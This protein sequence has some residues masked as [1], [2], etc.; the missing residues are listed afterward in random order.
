[1]SRTLSRCGSSRSNSQILVSAAKS[2]EQLGRERF[3]EIPCGQVV[4]EGDL[5]RSISGDPAPDQNLVDAIP[6]FGRARGRSRGSRPLSLVRD[7]P[8]RQSA[9]VADRP[10]RMVACLS[11]ERHCLPSLGSHGPR[12]VRHR[13]LQ[14]LL[15]NGSAVEAVDTSGNCLGTYGVGR[16]AAVVV[17]PHH[18]TRVRCRI[19]QMGASDPIHTTARGPRRA[20]EKSQHASQPGARPPGE[21]V[22]R[23]RPSPR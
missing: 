10:I 21:T 20:G 12:M 2:A 13:Y 11:R 4:A 15:A 8:E 5:S 19:S 16:T 17:H 9:K 1:M 3:G 22:A 14:D 18:M 7:S 6:T 23:R